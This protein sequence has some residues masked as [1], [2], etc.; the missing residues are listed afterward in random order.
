MTQPGTPD[1][2]LHNGRFTTLDR[3]NPTASAVAIAEGRFIQVGGDREVLALAGPQT[4]RIDLGGR[5][6][7]PGLID[8]HLHIIRG[9]LNF[10]L[11][12]RW[13][14][15]RSLADAMAMLKAQVA[16]TPA[17][18]WVRVVGG[19]TEHQFVEKRLPTI[20]ELNAVAPD[21]PVF[22]LHLYDRALLNAAALR[23]VG[24]TK[25]TPAPPGGEIVR[26]ASGQ[27]TGLLL[28]KPN[29]A[30]L[31]ATLA[32]GPKLPHEYQ[33]NSTRH[34]MRELNRLGVTGAIDAGGGFQ[35]YPEDYAVIQEL[36]DANQLTIRLAYNLFTQ[37]PKQ[38][39]DDFLKWTASSQYKQGS[40]Y[41]RHNGAGEMLVFSAAD[42]EDFRQPRPEMG[43]EMEGDLEE[44]VRILAQNRWPWRMH[45]TYDETIT[46]ALDVFEKVNKDTPLAGLNW[47][48]DHAETISEKSI[49]RVA[50]LGGGVA[51]QH[52][53]AY[54]GEY[55]ALRYGPGAAE[56]TPPVKRML[57]MGVKVSAGT[58]ATRVASYNPWVSLS[59][60]ITG[61]TVGGMQITPQRNLIDRETALRMWTEKVTWFSNEEGRKGSIQAGQMADLIVPDRDFFAC[62]ESEIADTTSLLTLVGG[63]VVYGAGSFAAFDDAA[64]PPAMPDWSP[65]RRYGGYGAWGEREG[66]PLQSVMR[67]AAAACGCASSCNVHGHQHA[68]AWTSKLPVS[69]L[70]GFWGALGCACWAV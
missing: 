31:Y 34:F 2:I 58:D 59:W 65:V 61:K 63:R 23:A 35:N 4:R 8:N 66:A 15:V 62:A 32:K 20:E 60:L 5:S 43:P 27:P 57:E 22:I 38:E 68:T 50:A 69:D 55:F 25:D 49:E 24:Y 11:E 51:V 16:I 9:G 37:K 26:D 18:Q 29:A 33:V 56:A 10:N 47:F 48:F 44:V 6:V 42:F 3:A 52:R 41:F 45:A 53:M 21:T 64:P 7:L 54:Q 40:D 36:A 28:A 30:I 1:L 14:G 70:K 13:D 12:L 46:R 67:Q 19:F 17:P 39:K